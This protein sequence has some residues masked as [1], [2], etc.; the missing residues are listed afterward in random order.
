M[1]EKKP[2]MYPPLVTIGI[3]SYKRRDAVTHVLESALEQNYPNL[4]ILVVDNGSGDGMAEWMRE[5][6]P[7]VRLIA[8][9]DNRGTGARN[10]IIGAAAGEYLVMLDNDVSLDGPAAIWSIVAGF[11]RHPD[12]GCIAFRV[13]HPS[14]RTLHV[15]DWCHPRPWQTGESQEFETHYITEGA[16]AFRT[17]VFRTVDCY[18]EP[19]FIGH[20]GYDLGLRLMD[21]GYTIWYVPD[22]RVWHEASV[23][24]RQDW[25]PFYFYTRNLFPIAYRNYP[26]WAGM[27]YVLP[28]VLVFGFY[29]V[30]ARAFGRFIQ[31]LRDGVDMIRKCDRKRQPVRSHTL[32]RI[33]CIKR[34]QENPIMRAVVMG[35]ERMMPLWR[36]S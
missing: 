23:E 14:T 5:T 11:D 29:A 35:R 13:Y 22:V 26:L 6:F 21:A 24:T 18:W 28:R 27:W 3:L 32:S 10:E 20:E 2:T 9:E 7:T 31:A 36:R 34:Q 15:R 25:R 16:C 8:L 30:R 12:A 4:E 17:S 33:S 1:P 19:L